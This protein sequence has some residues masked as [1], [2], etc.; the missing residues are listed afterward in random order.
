MTMLNVRHPLFRPFAITLALLLATLAW[1]LWMV[2][3]GSAKLPEEQRPVA[4]TH[5]NYEVL[6]PFAPESFHQ[7]RLQAIGRLVKVEERSVFLKEV[8]RE[9][10]I[11][12]SRQ[13]W[14]VG[15]RRWS[16]Q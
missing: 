6:F 5:A 3:Q 13:Y 16:D 10:A 14:V 4:G 8:S 11:A 15:M 1:Q 9:D 2:V 7:M 12:L